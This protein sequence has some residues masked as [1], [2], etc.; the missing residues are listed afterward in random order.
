MVRNRGDNLTAINITDW[1]TWYGDFQVLNNINSEFKDK[2]ITA[3]VGPSG[4]GKTTLL[5][6]LN[7]TAEL[8]DNFRYEGSILVYGHNIYADKAED[9][10]RHIGL[11]YQ[12]P[13]ALPL[14]IQENV[15]FGPRYY[16][17]RKRDRLTA[18]VENCLTQA[19]LWDEVKDKLNK[20]AFEL[21]GGQKQRLS[22]ARA[23]AVNPQLLLLDEPCSSLDPLSTGLIEEL[24][25]KLAMNLPIIIVT[26]NL[27]QAR[28]IANETV[29]MLNGKII[30]K[31]LTQTMFNN[32]SN[33]ATRSFFSGAIG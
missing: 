6:S 10:R 7:R 18:I 25:V 30:E 24:L 17:E 27:F 5:R 4:C 23:L 29:F 12:T 11:V 28:R 14:S 32:P 33:E 22:I 1:N 26:H 31:D 15:L 8:T 19:A 13:V 21:S 3:I 9:A 2:S 20:P 16:G